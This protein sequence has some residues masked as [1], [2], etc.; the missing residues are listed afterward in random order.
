M[1]AKANTTSEQ[2]NEKS[3]EVGDPR[4]AEMEEQEK[5]KLNNIE[6]HPAKTKNSSLLLESDYYNIYFLNMG[7][8]YGYP[9]GIPLLLP[10]KAYIFHFNKLQV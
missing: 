1:K 9:L 8:K 3:T 4:M 10:S 7:I 5:K 6:S 2:S